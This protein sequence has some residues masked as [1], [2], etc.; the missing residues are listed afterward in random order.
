[1]VGRGA[2]SVRPVAQIMPY[3]WNKTCHAGREVI[4][5]GFSCVCESA[6]ADNSYTLTKLDICRNSL[7]YL[8]RNVA[9]IGYSSTG[10]QSTTVGY[11]GGVVPQVSSLSLTVRPCYSETLCFKVI[12]GRVTRVSP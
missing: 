7:S 2:V 6:A 1:M 12:T 8:R 10:E 3:V 5:T 9:E 11:R 4:L